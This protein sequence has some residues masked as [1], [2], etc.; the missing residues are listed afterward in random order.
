MQLLH[1]MIGFERLGFKTYY[2]EWH[3]N[4]VEDPKTAS[5]DPEKPRMVVEEVMQAYGFENRWICRGDQISPGHTFGG[6]SYKQL[7]KL[8][9][10]AEAI[11]NVTGA[12]LVEDEMMQCPR[13]VYV[14]SDPGIPQIK[15]KNDDQK[16]LSLING[17]T[18]HFTFGENIYHS[19]CLLPEKHVRYKPTRQPVVMDL[20]DDNSISTGLNFTTIARWKKYKNKTIDF[21]DQRYHWNKDR[22][23]ETF[24]D[25]PI[26]SSQPMELALSQVGFEEKQRLQDHG[27]H[28]VDALP[29]S[30]SDSRYR[31]YIQSSRGEFTIAKDQY[32]RLNTGWFSDRSA[33]YL[34]SGRPVITQDTKFGNILPVGEGLFSFQTMEDILGALD[35]INSDYKKHCVAARD[36]ALEYFEANKVLHDLLVSIDLN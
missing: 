17:H 7:C 23:F 31:S 34:A 22:E 5:A 18:H 19:D 26:I 29:L 25:L 32:V 9:G 8:Y 15:L 14:E 35:A 11:I 4:W 33:C 27:W 13:R 10:E 21:N 3:G 28:V 20:W 1:Y 24:I 12:H 6:M 36:I 30:S 16:I 2:V